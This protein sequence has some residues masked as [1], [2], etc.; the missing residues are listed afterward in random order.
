MPART[1]FV[2]EAPEQQNVN[3]ENGRGVLKIV[4]GNP[5]GIVEIRIVNDVLHHAAGILL[6]NKAIVRQRSP[7]KQAKRQVRQNRT[8]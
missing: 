4:R 2:H 7:R 8:P 5:P 3:D 1:D 6:K